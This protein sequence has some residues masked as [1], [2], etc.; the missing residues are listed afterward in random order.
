MKK[1]IILLY[2]VFAGLTVFAADFNVYKFNNGQT[3][4]IKEVKTNPIVIIDTWIKTGSVNETDKNSGV[5]HFLEHLFF[6]GTEKY[7]VGQMDKLLDSKGAVSNAATSKD[8]THYYITIPSKD[9]DL[10]L[11]LHSD[12]LLNP[13]IPRKEMEKERKVVLEEIAKDKNSPSKLTFDNLNDMLYLTHPYKRQVIGKSDVI[14]TITREEVLNFYDNF[15]SPSNMVTIVVGDIDSDVAAEKIR[16]AFSS[17]SKKSVSVKTYKEFP[18]TTQKRNESY[19]DTESGYM[20]IGFRSVATCNADMYALDVLAAIL[21]DGRTSRFYQRIKDQKR[22]AYSISASNLTYKQD[23]MFIITANFVPELKEKLEKAI[24]G[25]ITDI[26]LN[27]VTPL[28]LKTA[29]NII[30]RDTF[31]SRESVS[32]IASEIGYTLVLTGNPENYDG[33]LEGIKKVTE[34]DVKR[35]AKKYLGEN[36]SAVAITLPESFKNPKK[37]AVKKVDYDAKL[38][39]SV[40]D[41]DKYVLGNDAVL[42]LNKHNQNDIVAITIYVKG[43]EFLEK[44]PGEA[45]LMTGL[46]LKGTKNYS[47]IELAQILEENG[48]AIS[49]SASSDVFG[50]NVLT[51]KQQLPLTLSL[52]NEVVNNAT[53]EDYEIE[54]SKTNMLNSIKK[55]RDVPINRALETYKSLIYGNSVYSNNTIIFE[56]TIPKIKREDIV[57]YYQTIFNPKNIVISINGNIDEKLMIN[58]FTE[59]FKSNNLPQIDFTKY[60]SSISAI[61]HKQEVYEIKD[62]K[63]SWLIMGWQVAGTDNLKDFATLQIMDTILGTGMSSRLFKSLREQEG[64]A[65]QV[66]S[67]YSPNI[68]RGAFTLYIGTNPNSLEKSRAKMLQEIEIL[69]TKFVTDKELQEAKD[70]LIGQYILTLETNLSKAKTLALYEISG[71]GFEFI[72]DYEKLINNVTSS[73]IIEVANKYFGNNYI[74]SIVDIKK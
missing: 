1:I 43:G 31:Y 18:L 57:K 63:T 55:N 41:A 54:K 45:S 69:K 16:K 22:L 65:Y 35:V 4:I 56:K 37:E 13:Q 71:R 47:A 68:L 8:F 66:G 11:D 20:M 64:L 29:K 10:A 5:A 51:T 48:I 44:I 24:F 39:K 46:M 7:P 40:K 17:K 6:K 21:G 70:Q 38:V 52:L 19:Y 42:I 53:F 61:T 26:Q 33:Y 2:V 36:K 34:S 50:I 3:V 74:E 25:E 72:N 32:N 60:S 73:D 15:Y 58:E 30:E 49:P 23:G 62:L 59:M 67:G 9:F 14:E 28:E 27:G 12:M